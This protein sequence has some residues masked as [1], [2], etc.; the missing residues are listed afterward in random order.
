MMMSKLSVGFEF[1][2]GFKG[3][4]RQ[5]AFVAFAFQKVA[6]QFADVFFVVGD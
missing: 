6:Q 4:G 2:Q 3:V 1:L 5:L